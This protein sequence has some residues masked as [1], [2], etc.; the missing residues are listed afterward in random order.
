M[1]LDDALKHA[2]WPNARAPFG[3]VADAKA[4]ASSFSA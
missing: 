3:G 4:A 1:F 2:A